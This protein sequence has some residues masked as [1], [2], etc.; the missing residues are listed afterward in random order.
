VTNHTTPAEDRALF[1][2][3]RSLRKVKFTFNEDQI[4]VL[5][6][7]LVRERSDGAPTLLPGLSREHDHAMGVALAQ[8]SDAYID[9]TTPKEGDI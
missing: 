3:V 8:L 4:W 5:Y 9:L 2:H 7:L 1:E 6:R